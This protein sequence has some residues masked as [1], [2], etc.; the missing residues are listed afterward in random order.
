MC[1]YVHMSVSDTL[2]LELHVLMRH[3][4]WDPNSGIHLYNHS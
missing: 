2:E 4:R 3:A 1:E